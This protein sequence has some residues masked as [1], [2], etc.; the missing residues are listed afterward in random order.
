MKR[1]LLAI[2]PAVM[3]TA[4]ASPPAPPAPIHT[5]VTLLPTRSA[6]LAPDTSLRLDQVA[7]S[8]CPPNAR[9]VWAGEVRFHFTLTSGAGAEAFSLTEAAP[10]AEL[11]AA[12]GLRVTLGHT[13][14]PAKA[15]LGT[16]MP[17]YPVT[18]TIDSK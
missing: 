6:Q 17:D 1:T 13:S 8:R 11:A 15:A 12:G 3:M 7:D 18:V 2:A 16:P 9:C 5:T 4:C 14:V 10:G